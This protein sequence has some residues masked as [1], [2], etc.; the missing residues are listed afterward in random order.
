MDPIATSQLGATLWP[1]GW[2][3]AERVD[4]AFPNLT[5]FVSR[6]IGSMVDGPSG[7]QRVLRA[8]IVFGDA[9]VASC[10]RHAPGG[11][12][13]RQLFDARRTRRLYGL[14]G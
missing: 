3:P 13:S 4:V 9:G 11:S 6:D 1:A 7:A 14:T 2:V 12:I 10:Q 5:Q 8:F